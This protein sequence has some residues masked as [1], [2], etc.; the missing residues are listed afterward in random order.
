MGKLRRLDEV[1][2]ERPRY[3]G[4]SIVNLMASIVAAGEGEPSYPTL[5]GLDAYKLN[6][7]RN[8]ILIVVDGLGYEHLASTDAAPAPCFPRRRRPPSRPF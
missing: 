5:E 6:N 4:D 7:S 1:V 2:V 8:L 3:E